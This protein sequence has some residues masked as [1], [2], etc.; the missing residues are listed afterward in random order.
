MGNGT[1]VWINLFG[2]YIMNETISSP[3]TTPAHIHPNIQ[4]DIHISRPLIPHQPL[5]LHSKNSATAHLFT[6]PRDVAESV[7]PDRALMP[8]VTTPHLDANLF[9]THPSQKILYSTKKKAHTLMPICAIRV[10]MSSSTVAVSGNVRRSIAKRYLPPV[11]RGASSRSGAC[12]AS[13][14]A[15]GGW[16][17]GQLSGV[18]V[19]VRVKW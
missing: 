17:E 8:R 13:S 6:T 12:S 18:C 11:S 10:R 4:N 9:D 19:E 5:H 3:A 16:D 7:W 15:G 1:K 2:A 14:S